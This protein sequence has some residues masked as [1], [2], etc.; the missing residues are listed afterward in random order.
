MSR[1]RKYN[2]ENH[3]HFLTGVINKRMKLFQKYP[4]CCQIFLENLNFYKN[5]LDFKFLG[6]VIMPEHYHLL[7]MPSSKAVISRIL[8][9]LKGYSAKKIIEFLRNEDIKFLNKLK[10]PV[11]KIKRK[12]DSRY[13]IFKP[14]DYDFNIFTQDKL[15]EKLNYMHNNPVKRGLV[16]KPTKYFYSSSRNYEL[17]DDSFIKID[18]LF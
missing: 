14:D 1:K 10:L 9:V 17:N 13:R 16:E 5:R 12:K 15:I 3:V 6:Y 2:L 18:R 11:N 7:I 4:E 8:M